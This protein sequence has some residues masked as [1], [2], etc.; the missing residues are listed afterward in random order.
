MPPDFA[1]LPI[2]FSVEAPA[3]INLW[4]RVLGRR[5]DGF[6]EVETRLA[7]LALSDRLSLVRDESLAEGEIALSCDDPTV[8]G[9]ESNLVVR[10][11][12]A[13]E[14]TTGRLP[15]LR[16]HLEKRIPHG[17]GL[18]G[19]SSDAAA[20]LR[21]VEAAFG[22]ALEPGVLQEA[23][24]AVGSDV[25]FF[26][27]GQVADARGRGEQVVAVPERG[28]AGRLLLVK[29]PFGVPTPWAY[30]QWGDS[31]ELEGLPY[32]PQASAWGELRNDLERPVFEKYQVLGHL[33]AALLGA[34]GVAAALMS[35]S[36]STVFAFLEEGADS[37]AAR[38]AVHAEVGAEVLIVETQLAPGLRPIQQAAL[39][40]GTLGG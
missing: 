20:A 38:A 39:R 18:G 12:R 36:G 23:A 21:L 25:P 35:G 17:A 7:P 27:L 29:L 2:C 30:R 11:L 5:G 3:K 31:L 40:S 19:G 10:A 37:A 32:G 6:H 8:P 28:A 34:P 4:L 16:L 24:A 33:K 9:D 26:L 15:G 13:L 14:G 22:L 1:P